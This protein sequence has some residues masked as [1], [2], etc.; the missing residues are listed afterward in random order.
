M[1]QSKTTGGRGSV[2]AGDASACRAR[3]RWQRE[4]TRPDCPP[5]LVGQA[6]REA[7]SWS[8]LIVGRFFARVGGQIVRVVG[9]EGHALM[10]NDRGG[11]RGDALPSG[12]AARP[13]CRGERTRVQEQKNQQRR[14]RPHRVRENCCP[15]S[16]LR[17]E[18]AFGARRSEQKGVVSPVN[19]IGIAIRAAIFLILAALAV[20]ARIANSVRLLFSVGRIAA[21]RRAQ[22][23][24]GRSFMI[25]SL[26]ASSCDS[27]H[28]PGQLNDLS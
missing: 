23:R 9:G 11:E 10:C 27:N 3:A 16:H 24:S 19:C 5:E 25:R 26:T 14:G 22:V 21:P 12:Q 28:L 18:Q 1:S 13:I 4:A 20:K 7:G 8:H 2:R 6:G 15:H 17:S